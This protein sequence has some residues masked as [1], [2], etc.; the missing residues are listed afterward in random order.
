MMHPSYRPQAAALA[1][2]SLVLPGPSPKDQLAGD[3][4]GCGTRR[5]F[6]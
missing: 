3:G 6:L 5:F 4:H 2:R 1:L